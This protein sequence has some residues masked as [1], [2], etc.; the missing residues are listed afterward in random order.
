M[1][2]VT[3]VHFT[4]AIPSS[5]GSDRE[6]CWRIQMTLQSRHCNEWIRPEAIYSP[7]Y[8]RWTLPVIFTVQTVSHGQRQPLPQTDK[9]MNNSCSLKLPR[10]FAKRFCLLGSAT[11][12]RGVRHKTL[13]YVQCPRVT[14]GVTRQARDQTW[15][16]D[17][18]TQGKWIDW[19]TNKINSCIVRLKQRFV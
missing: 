12:A 10:A 8:F 19:V 14:R 16:P 7:G 6:W 1:F 15:R 3:K 17:W 18:K 4:A 13:A 9:W 2:A 5:N 11:G